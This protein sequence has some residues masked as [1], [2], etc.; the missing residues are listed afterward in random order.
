MAGQ[1]DLGDDVDMVRTGIV[2]QF[3]QVSG[4][5]GVSC[6][7]TGE[8]RQLDAEAFPVG[9]VQMEGGELL[10]GHLTDLR[11]EVADGEELA[12]HVE[13]LRTLLDV[14][15]VAGGAARDRGVAVVEPDGLLDG[16]GGVEDPGVPGGVHL[17]DVTYVQRVALRPE[18]GIGATGPQRDVTS[19]RSTGDDGQGAPGESPQIG[20]ERT[21]RGTE[22]GGIGATED[23]PGAG[24]QTELT[25]SAA[26]FA[27]PGLNGRSAIDGGGSGSDGRGGGGGG[28]RDSEGSGADDEQYDRQDMPDETSHEQYRPEARRL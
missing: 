20:R 5:V 15:P 12:P 3:P 26:P 27:D 23:D 13:H 24:R 21:C 19:L 28:A 10:P 14:R 18:L 11:L 2:L 22:F 25:V 6:G 1:V 9:E 4:V 8:L 17:Q 7:K 16:L